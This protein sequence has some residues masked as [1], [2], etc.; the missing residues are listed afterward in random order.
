M[1]PE[2]VRGAS[3]LRIRCPEGRGVRIPPLAHMH[4]D[5]CEVMPVSS[6]RGTGLASDVKLDLGDGCQVERESSS[7]LEE[8]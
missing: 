8:E 4:Q 1:G 6:V 7:V 2:S 5:P 3:S